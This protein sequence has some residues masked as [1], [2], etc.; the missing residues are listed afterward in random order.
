MSEPSEPM[1]VFDAGGVLVRICRAWDEG[2]RRAGIEAPEDVMGPEAIAR[3]RDLSYLYQSGRLGEAEYFVRMAEAIGSGCAADIIARVHDA[4][5]IE[6]Y[7]GARALVEDLAA[8]GVRTALLSN[9]N[10][11]HWQAMA[12][13]AG[14]YPAIARLDRWFLSHELGACKPDEAIYAAV[15][16]EAHAPPASIIFFDD[17]EEN[18]AAATRRG[19]QGRQVD[20]C[21]DP[22]ADMRAHLRALGVL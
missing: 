13:G 9:T 19:W 15:E 18:V 4:W 16:R 12:P 20:H 11:R 6:E 7:P 17:L 5:L 21:G 10:A 2:A 1:V 8:A 3:R 14:L 22:A